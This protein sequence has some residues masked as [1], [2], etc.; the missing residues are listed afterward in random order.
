M[1]RADAAWLAGIIDGEGCLDSPRGNPRIRI[2]MSDHDVVLR[3]ATLMGASTYYENIEGRKS[4]LVAQITGARAVEVMREILPQLGSRR[5]QKASSITL[6]YLH[7]PAAKNA[8]QP[9]SRRRAA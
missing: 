2:K 3:A 6:A 7:R 1:D 4:L 8:V 5:S 9:I